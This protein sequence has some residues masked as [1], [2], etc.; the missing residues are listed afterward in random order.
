MP[1]CHLDQQKSHF[2]CLPFTGELLL[3]ARRNVDIET[4]L[5]NVKHGRVESVG[6]FAI[7]NCF[8]GVFLYLYPGSQHFMF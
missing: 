7:M 6:F 3:P 4:G 2:L 5:N 1:L 8:K